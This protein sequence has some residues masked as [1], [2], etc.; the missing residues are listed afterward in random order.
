MQRDEFS[1]AVRTVATRLLY[2]L[3]ECFA[4][5]RDAN[6]R[7]LPYRIS[8]TQV[9]EAQG[10]I[11]ALREIVLHLDLEANA[12]ALAARSRMSRAKGRPAVRTT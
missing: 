11:A 12:G 2:D 8:K 9:A 10:A 3:S 7:P 5:R 1:S 6:G 4:V